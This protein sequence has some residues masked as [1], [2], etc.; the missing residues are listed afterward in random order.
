MTLAIYIKPES[1][2]DYFNWAKDDSFQSKEIHAKLEDS[3]R[4]VTQSAP[5]WS[6]I[7]VS[8]EQ[9]YRIVDEFDIM[10]IYRYVE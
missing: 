1:V 3:I 10:K 4:V 2:E 7:N 8:V 9:W 5:G 6:V